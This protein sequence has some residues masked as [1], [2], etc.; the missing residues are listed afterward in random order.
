MV[1]FFPQ[2]DLCD[3]FDGMLLKLLVQGSL[4]L[5][6]ASPRTESTSLFESED[7]SGKYRESFQF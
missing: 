7:K 3:L 6:V 2:Y 4:S 5:Q 1:Q